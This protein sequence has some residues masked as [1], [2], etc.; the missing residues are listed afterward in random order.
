MTEPT[1]AGPPLRRSLLAL[2]LAVLALASGCGSSADPRSRDFTG[3]P[4]SGEATVCAGSVLEGIDVSKYDGTVDWAKV[5][6]SGVVFAFARVSDGLHFPDATFDGH[7]SAM[8]A[9]GVVRGVYQYFE[10]GQSALDQANLMLQHIPDFGDGDLPPVI[11]VETMG[12]QSA[13]T[14]LV[15]VKTWVA[16]VQ[17]V[18]GRRPVIY[19]SPS[20]W[21]QLG[22]AAPSA[23]LWTAN[24]G[25]RCPS[26]PTAFSSF[27]FWQYSAT[28]KVPGISS[29]V[30]LDRFNGTVDDL[31]AYV[32]ASSV[33]GGGGGGGSGGTLAP[34]LVDPADGATV[35]GPVT[36][37]AQ[38]GGSAVRVELW[39]DGSLAGAAADTQLVFAWDTTRVGDGGH[40]LM[41]KSFDASGFSAQSQTATVTVSNAP[42]G[43]G[44]GG[45]SSGGGA[46]LAPALLPL[47]ALFT[48]RRSRRGM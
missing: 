9:A 36:V 14:V 26:V 11:D 24:W 13:N 20:F 33:G 2:P 19:A 37:T 4:A 3:A 16:R 43:G 18:T 45:C 42:A 10:P 6:A 32:K 12:G 34:Q 38:G 29:A 22:G 40:H 44:S 47:L 35:S 21:N 41:V 15:G 46:A 7:W 5:R 30:D 23:D 28:G 27:R 48:G 25:V 1:R 17:A 39:I 8:P 31:A